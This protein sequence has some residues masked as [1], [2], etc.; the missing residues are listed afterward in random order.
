VLDETVG[1]RARK[2]NPL[3]RSR[4]LLT[5]ADERLDERGRTKLL[6]LLRAADSHGEVHHLLA[7]RQEAVRPRYTSTAT[8][9]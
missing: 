9:S 8:R 5:K 3:Y 1:H 6:G 7:R 2:D 4:R